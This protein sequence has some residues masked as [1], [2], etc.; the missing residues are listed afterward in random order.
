MVYPAC[1]SIRA[2]QRALILGHAGVQIPRPT[3][4][5]VSQTRTIL[6]SR[7]IGPPPRDSV[8]PPNLFFERASTPQSPAS[9]ARAHPNPALQP[10]SAYLVNE[11]P[12]HPT[13]R[14]APIRRD[15]RGETGR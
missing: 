1:P 14:L 5:P 11:I 9:S 2:R 15:K 7:A 3:A 6:A 10:F 8:K 12:A 4:G 13:C